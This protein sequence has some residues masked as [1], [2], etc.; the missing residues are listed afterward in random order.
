MTVSSLSQTSGRQYSNTGWWPKIPGNQPAS[1]SAFTPHL[2]TYRRISAHN[3]TNVRDLKQVVTM[4][5]KGA[6]EIPRVKPPDLKGQR[7]RFPCLLLTQEASSLRWSHL[8]GP[9]FEAN[10]FREGHGIT[11]PRSQLQTQPL[12]IPGENP[13]YSKAAMGPV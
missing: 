8:W 7:K 13:A 11:T 9:Q 6:S 5:K 1:S 10:Y 12:P 4:Q 2:H 3:C